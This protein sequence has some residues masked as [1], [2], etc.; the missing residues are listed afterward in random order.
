MIF[1]KPNIEIRSRKG[2]NE[3]MTRAS[4]FLS[5]LDP[6]PTLPG[7]FFSPFQTIRAKVNIIQHGKHDPFPSLQ[8]PDDNRGLTFE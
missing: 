5:Y 7:P 1:T 3:V 4:L 8:G 2:G 6:Y